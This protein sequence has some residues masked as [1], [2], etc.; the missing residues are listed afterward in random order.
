[1]KVVNLHDRTKAKRLKKFQQ[2]ANLYVTN[3]ESFVSYREY[4]DKLNI[5][6][7]LCR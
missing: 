7:L 4:I 5:H 1:M 2:D 3:I 6:G